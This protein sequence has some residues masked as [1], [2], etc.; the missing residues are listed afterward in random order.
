[1]RN[2]PFSS[3]TFGSNCDPYGI[4]NGSEATGTAG[5]AT[6]TAGTTRTTATT[7]ASAPIHGF[8]DPQATAIHIGAIQGTDGSCGIG[9]IHF[10]EGEAARTAGF[11]VRDQFD[12]KDIAVGFEQAADFILGSI[13]R[14][15]TD[16]NGLGHKQIPKQKDQGP[17][18]HLRPWRESEL[19]LRPHRTIAA[20]ENLRS[21]VTGALKANRRR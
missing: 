3:S 15:V 11:P 4:A 18:G 7:G 5:T 2:R 6:G 21:N 20:P 12:G 1:L 8:I 19:G 17:D 14:Q 9:R 13:E 16:I 10:H